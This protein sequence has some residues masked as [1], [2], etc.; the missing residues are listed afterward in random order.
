MRSGCFE[1]I[2][3][4][5]FWG[6][7]GLEQKKE[8]GGSLWL[9]GWGADGGLESVVM[10]ERILVVDDEVD[11]LQI[12]AR[13]LEHAGYYV[14]AVSNAHDARA[15]LA[16]QP[17]DLVILDIHMPEEDGMSLLKHVHAMNPELPT[18][19]ITGY[20]AVGTV[21][22]SLRLNVR[23]YLCKPFALRKLLECVESSLGKA[24]A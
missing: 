15:H 7:E 17:F 9:C 16:G 2:C 12:C 14:T 19:L 20:P 10:Q 6:G 13:A 22:D 23:E 5:R 24:Q 18:M 21:I 1:F 8:F 3:T 4:V 11:V